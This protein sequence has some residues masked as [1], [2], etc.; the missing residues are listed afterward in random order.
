MLRSAFERGDDITDVSLL[1]HAGR[2]SLLAVRLQ[3]T[4]QSRHYLARSIPAAGP[5]EEAR[6][7]AQLASLLAA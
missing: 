1:A 6:I 4:L 5:I 2:G 7:G 3:R